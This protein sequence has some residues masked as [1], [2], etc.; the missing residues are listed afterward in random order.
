M[1]QT[2]RAENLKHLSKLT[3]ELEKL[4]IGTDNKTYVAAPEKVQQLLGTMGKITD[5]LDNEIHMSA[6]EIRQ[7]LTEITGNTETEMINDFV[8]DYEGYGEVRYT[9]QDV[10]DLYLDY[11]DYCNALED[12]RDPE[13]GRR[14]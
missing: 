3:Y 13:F 10:G 8:S 5:D 1:T 11:V 7:E 9:I 14:V 4:L 6:D 2:Y 12:S